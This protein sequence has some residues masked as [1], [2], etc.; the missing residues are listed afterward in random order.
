MGDMRTTS[1][2]LGVTLLLVGTSCPAWT[3]TLEDIPRDHWARPAVENLVRHGLL[4]GYPDGTFRGRDGLS[5]DE[6]AAAMMKLID[7]LEKRIHERPAP[8]PDTQPE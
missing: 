8:M 4:T 7:H 3:L 5:R 1:A 6:F 2:T